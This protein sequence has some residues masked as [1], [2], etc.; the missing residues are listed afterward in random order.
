MKCAGH[1]GLSLERLLRLLAFCLEWRVPVFRGHGGRLLVE[2]L[3]EALCPASNV[4]QW[5]ERGNASP[6]ARSLGNYIGIQVEWCRVHTHIFY[7]LF[8]PPR[9]FFSNCIATF[10]FLGLFLS[11]TVHLI[12]YPM[13]YGPTI[14]SWSSSHC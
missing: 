1:T 7:I 3:P 5:G 6:A 9:H 14:W 10:F 8:T 11:Q 4:R 13:R 2:P 12:P